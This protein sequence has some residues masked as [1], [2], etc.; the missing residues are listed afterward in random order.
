MCLQTAAQFGDGTCAVQLHDL[1][2]VVEGPRVALA[3]RLADALHAG[4]ASALAAV[5]RDFE[6]MGDSVA[7]LDAAAHAA[8]AYRSEGHAESA[9]ECAT[10]AKI[11]ANSIGA[12]TLALHEAR[13]L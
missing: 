3:A 2:A 10:R 13:D 9:F 1:T 4:N 7:A 6:Q 12:N 8:A 5:S 11:L